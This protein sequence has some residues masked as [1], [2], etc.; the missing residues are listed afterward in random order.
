M[1]PDM[2]SAPLMAK[3]AD[4]SSTISDEQPENLGSP[5]WNLGTHCTV[6]DK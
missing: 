4:I 2:I 6:L 3:E 5:Y 1:V